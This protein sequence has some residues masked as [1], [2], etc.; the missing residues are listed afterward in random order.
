MSP[1]KYQ[2]RREALLSFVQASIAQNGCTPSAAAVSKKFGWS[3]NACQGYIRQLR[4]EM[5]LPPAP[6]TYRGRCPLHS[7]LLLEL[8]R[9]HTAQHGYAPSL[10]WLAGESGLSITALRKHLRKLQ[11][12]GL[13]DFEPG[14][15]RSL[16]LQGG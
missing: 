1:S 10:R 14:I 5:D 3:P 15:P 8:I 2:Q 11:G 7:H 13:V 12:R 9:S 16:R 6:P 4:D